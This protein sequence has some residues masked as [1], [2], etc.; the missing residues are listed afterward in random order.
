MREIKI[1]LRDKTVMLVGPFTQVIQSLTT[2]LT[3]MGADVAIVTSAGSHNHASKFAENVSNAREISSDFGRAA[4]LAFELDKEEGVKDCISQVAEIFGGIDVVIDGQLVDCTRMMDE[5][6]EPLAADADRDL[7]TPSVTLIKGA[8]P[9]L[10]GRN[11]GRVISLIQGDPIATESTDTLQT[12]AI[13]EHSKLMSSVGREVAQSGVTINGIQLGVTEEYL[14]VRYPEKSTI[15]EALVEL[16][17]QH[18][19]IDIIEAQEISNV[20]MF[21]ASPMSAGLNGQSLV[22]NKGVN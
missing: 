11:R 16:N 8:L 10:T 6:G 13:A 12:R 2:G 18:P 22:I 17:S 4:A 1:K 3:E 21:L 5:E 9:F 14:L 19:K 7:L 20:V 15:K